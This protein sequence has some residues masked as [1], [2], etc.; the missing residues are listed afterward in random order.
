LES[1]KTQGLPEDRIRDA[2]QF[3]IKRAIRACSGEQLQMYGS[4]HCLCAT[5]LAEA[6]GNL[7]RKYFN[8][9]ANISDEDISLATAAMAY[10]DSGR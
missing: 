4:R 1:L 6:T 2:M 8:E 3:D 10:H 9:F 7:Y 5:L